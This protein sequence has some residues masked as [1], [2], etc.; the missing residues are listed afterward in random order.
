MPAL[1]RPPAAI[2]AL[3]AAV[4]AYRMDQVMLGQRMAAELS[5]QPALARWMKRLYELSSIEARYTVLP[6]AALPVGESRFSPGRPA[7]EVAST[8][9][10]MQ[11]YRREAP[12]LG[13]AAARRALEELSPDGRAESVADTITHVIAVS[14]TGFFAPGLD[15]AIARRLGLNPHVERTLVGFMGCAA[16]FNA[17]RLAGRPEARVLVVCVE[18]CSLHVQPG[19][20]RIDLVVASLFADGA[21]ACVIGAPTDDGAD[22]LALNGFYTGLAPDSDHEMVWDIGDHGFELYLSPDIPRRLGEVAPEALAALSAGRD[23]PEFWAIH[24]GGRAI[25]DRLAEIFAL[26]PDAIAT[27]LDVL[28]NYGNMSSATILFVLRAHRERLRTRGEALPG[29]AM[30]FG[31]GLVTEMAHLTYQP[32][33][34][35]RV[36]GAED[37]VLGVEA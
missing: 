36:L 21:G 16:C 9:E 20:G 13:A 30:A 28:R 1:P 19:Q 25:V 35:R 23:Q 24:P 8:A 15:L 31:P 7:A 12:E 6:D 5:A 26:P 22:H 10:R 33:A 14:C 11:I 17:L 29:V 18:L 3:G 4:P 27:T 37:R 34:E 2:L 32:G